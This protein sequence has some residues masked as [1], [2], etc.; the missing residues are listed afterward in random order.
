MPAATRRSECA[1]K[2]L[3]SFILKRLSETTSETASE[4]PL[5][6]TLTDPNIGGSRGFGFIS[7]GGI[8]VADRARPSKI[9]PSTVSFS[10][11][12]GTVPQKAGRQSQI[13]GAAAAGS[14]LPSEPEI[15]VAA[16]VC[17][18]VKIFTPEK[19]GKRAKT[20]CGRI[21]PPVPVPFMNLARG[22]TGRDG[23]P[24][25]GPVRAVKT[26]TA[27]I[28]STPVERF[29]VDIKMYEVHPV[30]KTIESRAGS[31]SDTTIYIKNIIDEN[32]RMNVRLD[33]IVAGRRVWTGR[34]TPTGDGRTILKNTVGRTTTTRSGESS[35]RSPER[36]WVE[37]GGCLLLG[38]SWTGQRRPKANTNDENVTSTS[39]KRK[40]G[41]RD[42]GEGRAGGDRGG[43]MK[44]A[45][46]SM[47]RYRSS[48][49]LNSGSWFIE[50]VAS[51][52]V[53]NPEAAAAENSGP[54][55][56]RGKLTQRRKREALP[57]IRSMVL[58]PRLELLP[59]SRGAEKRSA[60]PILVVICGASTTCQNLRIPDSIHKNTGLNTLVQQN[61]G[62]FQ[63]LELEIQTSLVAMQTDL[64]L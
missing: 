30:Q 15:K 48:F 45:V 34:S 20:V 28:P 39:L 35:M 57:M 40:R 17:H 5:D 37:R 49:F 10:N 55:L 25:T 29:K 33:I 56:R 26:A 46:S 64:R 4:T 44:E 21:R 9:R 41:N 27:S 32:I 38:P 12:S 63:P 54:Y 23:T 43:R 47:Y 19:L 3:K 14:N 22:L 24:F 58:S 7:G 2:F 52:S 1:K 59:Q 6:S 61:T 16:S 62:I 51:I 11:R 50:T 53:V 42:G 36:A 13:D 18:L 31:R 8:R 60:G